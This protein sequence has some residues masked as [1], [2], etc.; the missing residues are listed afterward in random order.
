VVDEAFYLQLSNKARV[1]K[2]I[3][4]KIFRDYKILSRQE[5]IPNPEL[6]HFNKLIQHFKR[7]Q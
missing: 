6:L 2:D 1:E 3:I 5:K 4:K 7:R